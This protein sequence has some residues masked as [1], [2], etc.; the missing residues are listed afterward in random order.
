MTT[1]TVN[2]MIRVAWACGQP[3]SQQHL[4]HALTREGVERFV[5][6]RP[7]RVSYD[8]KGTE[9]KIASMLGNA[10]ATSYGEGRESKAAAYEAILAYCFGYTAE[11]LEAVEPITT[12]GAKKD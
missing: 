1:I 4:H 3:I 5:Q 10:R 6:P 7:R 8:R 9:A 12:V 11:Q 2:E